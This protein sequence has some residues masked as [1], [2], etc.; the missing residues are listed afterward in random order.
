[1]FDIEVESTGVSF[2]CDEND[3]IMRA[4][5]RA[6]IPFPYECNVGQCGSCRF[7]LLEGEVESLWDEAPALTPRDIRK[8][9]KLGCQCKVKSNCKIK[10]REDQACSPLFRPVIRETE[11]IDIRN[12][13]HDMREFRFHS[14]SKA[15]F[16]PGQYCLL[17]LPGISGPRAYSMCNLPNDQGEWHFLIKRFPNGSGTGYLFDHIK[18]GD[19]ITLD[20]PYGLAYLREEF[21]K[22]IVCIAGGSGLSPLISIASAASQLPNFEKRKIRFFFGGRGPADICGEEYLR[23]LPGFGKS[24]TFNA[25]ISVPELDPNGMCIGPVGFIHE[26]VEN[27]LDIQT[28][29]DYEFYIA[30]PPPMLQATLQMLAVKHKV[31]VEQIHFDRFF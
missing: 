11:L 28:L 4:A 8:G 19:K 29:H 16:K 26:S 27:I 7:E 6:G 12:V 13:T 24:I 25:A 17:S 30:G 18:I 21:S 9:L 2:S 3:T 23:L 20:G 1:M 5:L 15:E 14:N 22:D 10:V 31:N